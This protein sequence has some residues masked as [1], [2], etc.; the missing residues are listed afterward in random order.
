MATVSLLKL[1]E[2]FAHFVVA[3]KL[4]K[5]GEYRKADAELR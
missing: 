2:A 4:N 5:I 1:R 3:E